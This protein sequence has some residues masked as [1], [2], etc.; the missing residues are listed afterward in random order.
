MIIVPTFCPGCGAR[1]GTR[2]MPPHDVPHLACARCGFVHYDN[3]APCAGALVV[4]DADQLLL[5]RR[6]RAP[7]RGWWNVLG[8][9]IEGAEHPE[10]TARREVR[11]EAGVEV[12]IERLLGI[13]MDRYGNTPENTL[14]L[15]YLAR[16]VSGTPVPGDDIVALRWFDADDIPLGRV[17]FRN[18]RA[19][20]EAWLSGRRS[21]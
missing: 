8:G 9:F 15:I 21:P 2:P 1:L 16:W 14:N 13:W 12:R 11:E 7:Y 20:V 10:E 18:G 6:G 3:P 4:N 17:A 19:A 5:G